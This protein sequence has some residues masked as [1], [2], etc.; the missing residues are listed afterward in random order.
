VRAAL[1][2]L[3]ACGSALHAP[4]PIAKF[5]PRQGGGRSADTLVALAR[6]AQAEHR[7]A[8]AQGLY[9]DAAVADDGRIDAVLG[10]MRAI[11][12][13][14]EHEP[15]VAKPALSD[16]EVQLGQWCQRRAPASAECDYR[17]AI[18]LGQYAREH[19]SAG[20]DAMTQMV[21]L[22]RRVIAVN[23]ALDDGGPHRV[24]ALV[25]LRAPGWPVGPGDP[26]AGLA[27]ARAAVALAPHS[28]ANQDV[29]REAMAV[30]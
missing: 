26:E 11:A 29:L 8:A 21:A 19:A 23:P 13:R 16:E 25:L 6:R 2:V 17:L 20:H 4:S 14:I 7:A 9:L 30:Q 10:A 12:D 27:E 22:L 3:A 18:A 28:A 24:L 5:A 15:G 1:I